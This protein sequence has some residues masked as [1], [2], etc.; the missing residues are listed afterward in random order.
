MNR[1][2]NSFFFF[3]LFQFVVAFNA[4]AQDGWPDGEAPKAKALY[5]GDSKIEV[6]GLANERIWAKY[7]AYKIAK[8]VSQTPPRSDS[9]FSATFKVA[10]NKAYLYAFVTVTDD[11][12]VTFDKRADCKT[13]QTDCVEFFINPDGKTPS[14]AVNDSKLGNG[15]EIHANPGDDKIINSNLNGYGYHNKIAPVK[16]FQYKSTVTETGYQIEVAMPFYMFSDSLATLVKNENM[17]NIEFGFDVNVCDADN[18]DAACNDL[19]EHIMTWSTDRTD[20]FR[21]TAFYGIL[22]LINKE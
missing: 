18:P 13:W 21:N 6:D 1:C 3:M 19:R 16:D 9:D 15:S 17:K 4:I 22:S 20:N 8:C 11:T 12:V 7:P 2:K 14:T 10:W 5:A